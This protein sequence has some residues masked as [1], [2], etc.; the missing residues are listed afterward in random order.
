PGGT[1]CLDQGLIVVDRGSRHFC[2][3]RLR[4]L[5]RQRTHPSC[6][7]L[8]EH[9]FAGLHAGND[10]RA[11]A[12]RSGPPAAMRPIRHG[13]DVRAGGPPLSWG[14]DTYSAAAP[15]WLKSMSPYTWVPG[16]RDLTSPPT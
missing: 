6:A 1:Q 15:S 10:P 3:Q 11:P 4:K 16:V 5:H 12:T 7:T 8:D 9:S 2:S 13:R 14:N